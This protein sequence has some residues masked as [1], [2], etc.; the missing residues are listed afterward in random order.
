MCRGGDTARPVQE[1]PFTGVRGGG[2]GGGGIHSH[3]CGEG[4]EGR[5]H[6][7][8]CT[9]LPHQATCPIWPHATPLP[10]LATCPPLPHQDT[11]NPLPHPCCALACPVLQASGPMHPP[12]SPLLCPGLPCT[13]YPTGPCAFMLGNEGQGLSPKQLA[14]C[15]G[16]VYIPQYGAGTASLNVAVAAS[17]VLHHYAVWAGRW[18]WWWG[19]QGRGATAE[20]LGGAKG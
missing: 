9:P 6:Q 5:S 20:W 17:I 13:R 8:T 15:D 18:Q 2:T 1:H 16:F 10:H 3:V 4:R 19:A 11:Y 7:A 14:L 12:A